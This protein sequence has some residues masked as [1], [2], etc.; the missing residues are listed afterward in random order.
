VDSPVATLSKRGTWDFGLFYERGT[1]RFEIFLLDQGL[2]DAFSKLTGQHRQ[3]LPQES[4]V[5]FV[6]NAR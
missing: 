6:G 2:V 1:D 4:E 3:V 5:G